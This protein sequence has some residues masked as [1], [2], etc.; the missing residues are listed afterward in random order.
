MRFVSLISTF[1]LHCLFGVGYISCLFSISICSS[2]MLLVSI[3]EI[4]INPFSL[5]PASCNQFSYVH[6]LNI[7]LHWRQFRCCPFR[8]F[9]L[10]FLIFIIARLSLSGEYRDGTCIFQRW[11]TYKVTLI[12]LNVLHYIQQLLLESR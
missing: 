11:V 4:W 9:I 6:S 10:F 12:P 5:Q 7:S 3:D 1:S 2:V 8:F